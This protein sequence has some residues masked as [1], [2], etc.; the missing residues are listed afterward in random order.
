MDP[1]AAAALGRA[2]RA[3]VERHWTIDRMVERFEQPTS[4]RSRHMQESRNRRYHA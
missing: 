4:R 3:E 2:A 1:A